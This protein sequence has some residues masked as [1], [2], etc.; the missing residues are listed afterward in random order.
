[1]GSL[2][3]RLENELIVA[4]W[5][6]VTPRAFT[7]RAVRH[8]VSIAV[9]R[10]RGDSREVGVHCQRGQGD[11]MAPIIRDSHRSKSDNG[12]EHHLL[13]RENKIKYK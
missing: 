7:A 1:M 2:D 9:R 5:F 4:T 3:S 10:L 6:N 11:D 13:P 8:R 12:S